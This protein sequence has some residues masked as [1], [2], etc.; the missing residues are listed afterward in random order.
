MAQVRALTSFLIASGVPLPV[1]AQRASHHLERTAETLATALF[2]T[3]DPSECLL[4]LVAAGH[5]PPFIRRADGRLERLEGGRRPIL[6]VASPAA[7]PLTVAL[8]A[9]DLL[10][11]YTDGLI[12]RR[13][14][15]LDQGLGRLAAVVAT[16]SMDVP[17]DEIADRIL[18][19]CVP[20]QTEDDVALVLVRLTDDG[21]ARS[22]GVGD[23][24]AELERDAIGVEERQERQPERDEVADRPVLDTPL[25]EES[26][27]VVQGGP[28]RGGE[29]EVVE[30]D[31]EG[32]EPVGGRGALVVDR[33]EPEEHAVV[34]QDHA[35]LQ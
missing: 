5:V 29:A 10:V 34:H 9:G 11:A 3:V 6:G 23:R 30:P 18:A 22:G 2:L 27:R 35:A 1:V 25:V 26:R 19:A 28:R 21:P 24:R 8:E 20:E 31:A 16:A 13:T 7:T 14:E 15:S 33:S 32:V 12:E 17:I 4:Q